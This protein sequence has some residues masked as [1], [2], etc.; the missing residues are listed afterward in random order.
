MLVPSASPLLL[1]ALPLTPWVCHQSRNW[2][3]GEE[4][5]NE[6]IF[7]LIYF[8][9]EDLMW[10]QHMGLDTLHL[11]TLS[12]TPSRLLNTYWHHSVCC[13]PIS[14]YPPPTTPA[15]L[16]SARSYKQSISKPKCATCFWQLEAL[17]NVDKWTEPPE[18]FYE[19][20]AAWQIYLLPATESCTGKHWLRSRAQ[21]PLPHSPV[22]PV[23]APIQAPRGC[24]PAIHQYFKL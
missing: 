2:I 13:P 23:R 20:A 11:T 18:G 16:K 4:I 14:I 19:S 24:W 8:S 3:R 10:R 9:N 12:S 6:G 7:I 22:L 5:R 15:P 1:Q 21:L 17:A